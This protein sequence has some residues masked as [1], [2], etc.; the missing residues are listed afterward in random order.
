MT[1]SGFPI[2]LQYIYTNGACETFARAMLAHPAGNGATIA[3]IETRDPARANED[4][5]HTLLLLP[6]GRLLDAEGIRTFEEVCDDFGVDAA[7]SRLVPNKSQD[8]D[9]HGNQAYQIRLLATLLGWCGKPP[10]ARETRTATNDWDLARA[11]F[12]RLG[13]WNGNPDDILDAYKTEILK[14]RYS[15]VTGILEF[16]VTEWISEPLYHNVTCRGHINMGPC[17]DFADEAE[18]LIRLRFGDSKKVKVLDSIDV[19]EEAGIETMDYHAFLSI[20]GLYYDATETAGVPDPF[21]I[22]FMA[23]IRRQAA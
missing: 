15:D 13:G 8:A 17:A 5:F 9:I 12:E 2:G 14:E 19:A 6:D 10:L 22:S 20:D 11:D 23:Q 18:A 3:D 1:A 4:V 21:C 16:L 7:I